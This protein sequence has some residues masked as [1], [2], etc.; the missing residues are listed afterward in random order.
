MS[1]HTA[2][3]TA[4]STSMAR[5][6]TEC[7]KGSGTRPTLIDSPSGITLALSK[8]AENITSPKAKVARAR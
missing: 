5:F 4:T 6:P 8:K 1:T 3:A 7:M 2:A